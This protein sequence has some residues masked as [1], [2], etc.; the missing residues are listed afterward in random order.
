MKLDRLKV[1]T[2]SF[3]SLLVFVVTAT[4]EIK[5]IPDGKLR[6]VVCDVGQGDA[7]YIKTPQGKNFLIDGGPGDQVLTCLGRE[8]PFWDRRI[9]AV[10]LTHPQADHMNGLLSVSSHY[11]IGHLF[12]GSGSNAPVY[13]SLIKKVRPEKLSA[14]DRI[15]ADSGVILS[16]L[17]P[18]ESKMAPNDENELSLVLLLEEPGRFRGLFAGD[19]PAKTQSEILSANPDLCCLD[20]LKIAHHGSRTG[21]AIDVLRVLTPK[22]AAISVG[23]DNQ[24]GHPNK[25]VLEALNKI[26]AKIERTD[27]EGDIV[28]EK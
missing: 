8:I 7:I 15:R 18:E 23:K 24:F 3:C 14:G 5:K 1:I 21:L 13:L 12:V 17:S 16:V 9:S 22:I 10:F 26:G 25:E 20:L 19:A 6:V 2:V 27:V 4:G 11:Q 28:V